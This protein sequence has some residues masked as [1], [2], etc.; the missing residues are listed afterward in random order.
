M[1]PLLLPAL[2][3]LA[4]AARAQ[5]SVDDLIEEGR[6]LLEIGKPRTAQEHFD[7]A[8]RLDGDTPRSRVW[9]VRGWIE[10][11][12]VDEA[13]TA[14]DEL[15]AAGAPEADL[16][17]LYGLGF[18]AAALA[19]VAAGGGTYTQ[20]RFEDAARFLA[21][22]TETDV[23]RYRD[24]LLP[25]AEAAWYAQDLEGAQAAVMRAIELRPDD[26]NAHMLHGRIAFSR[27]SAGRA[28]DGEIPS[29]ETEALWR[30]SLEAFQA[31][32]RAWGSPR[33]PALQRKLAESHQQ[34]GHLHLWKGDV[35]AAAP[36]Y[37][38]AMIFE[39]RALDFTQVHRS[40]G[41][42]ALAEQLATARAQFPK[43]HA[44]D[45]PGAALLAWWDGYVNYD[46]WNLPQAE[47]AF[48]DAIDGNPDYINAWYYV[49]RAAY[50]Q[51]KYDQALVALRT[52]WRQ[53]PISLVAALS[54]D[55]DKNLAILEFLIG[56]LIAP[57]NLLV[58]EPYREA[59]VVAEIQTRV[60]PGEP[61]FWNNLGLFLRD[62]GQQHERS[63]E[64]P[65]PEL[66][67]E[68]YEQAYAAYL[69]ALELGP[70]HPAYLNDTAVMLHYYLKRDWDEAQRLYELA[71]E[72]AD[73]GLAGDTL[74]NDLRAW[75]RTARGDAETNLR[76][77]ERMRA[78]R[79][80][81]SGRGAGS[82]KGAEE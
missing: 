55:K 74:P 76:R 35:Q 56:H 59:A 62:H 57:E 4:P 67:A 64:E 45:N 58:G 5:A 24:A 82:G 20:G 13:L 43:K 50:G 79:T 66:I 32:V 28:A 63:L 46:L 71:I 69:T 52:N 22:A 16:D 29:D 3:L 53:D 6:R 7:R 9:V 30:E 42:E 12:A 54:S 49:F 80:G 72:R 61:R 19:E 47:Q 44:D 37:G 48:H 81:K 73:E 60:V 78:D 31:A 14:T 70:E 8:A 11:G 26:G 10:A 77:L 1:L 23:E 38:A 15:K 25:Q 21:A 75:Y 65:A 34:I 68:I 18:H 36:A 40:I 51:R 17:Y 33:K 2:L 27:Y 39:P 41:S